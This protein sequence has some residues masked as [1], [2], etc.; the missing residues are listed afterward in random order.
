[1]RYHPSG[2]GPHVPLAEYIENMR[3]IASHL[4]SLSDKTRIIFLSCPPINEETFRQSTSGQ[5]CDPFQT[6]ESRRRYSEACIELCREMDLKV[7][8]LW[9]AIQSRDDWST[10]CFTDGIHFSAEGSKIVV[11]EILKVLKEAKWEPSL[12]WKSMPT[13]F[14]EDSPYDPVGLDGKS[15]VNTSNMTF[16]WEDDWE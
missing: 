14:G 7:I 2:L 13:E 3:R 6:N 15:T 8:D 16:H 5:I 1:M 4:K 11:K 10:A 9:T 12:Y